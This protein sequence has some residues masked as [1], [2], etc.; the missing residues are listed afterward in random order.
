MSEPAL[1]EDEQILH[2]VLA[3]DDIASRWAE[4]QLTR[5]AAAMFVVEAEI[6]ALGERLEAAQAASSDAAA[7]WREVGQAAAKAHRRVETAAGK[8]E[9]LGGRTVSPTCVLERPLGKTSS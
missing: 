3:N 4:G 5:A 2:A 8:L 6:R 7:D 9:K 1:H